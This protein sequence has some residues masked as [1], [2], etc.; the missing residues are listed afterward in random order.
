[1]TAE[2]A[3]LMNL[4]DATDVFRDRNVPLGAQGEVSV[5]ESG[6]TEDELLT[7]CPASPMSVVDES[8]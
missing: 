5:D 3:K 2:Q 7:Q 4:T 1:M 6:M 8:I